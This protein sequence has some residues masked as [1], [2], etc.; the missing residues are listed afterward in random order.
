MEVAKEDERRKAEEAKKNAE[1][2]EDN[3]PLIDLGKPN[4]STSTSKPPPTPVKTNAWGAANSTPS[5]SIKKNPSWGS[6]NSRPSS[7]VVMPQRASLNSR[8]STTANAA[9][10][11]AG[12]WTSPTSPNNRAGQKKDESIKGTLGSFVKGWL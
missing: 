8:L 4:T 3:I 9:N 5:P 11:K 10:S 12:S 7:P 1:D 2:D 6:A